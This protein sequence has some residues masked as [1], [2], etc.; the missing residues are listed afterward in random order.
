MNETRKLLFDMT[1]TL[2]REHV[3]GDVRLAAA[4]GQWPEGLWR[5]LEEAGL[6][7]M[8]VPEEAGGSGV[9]L[10]DALAVLRVAGRFAAP[11]PLAEALLASWLLARAGLPV[12]DGPLTLAPVRAAD[13]LRL[14]RDGDAWVLHGHAERVPWAR[15]ART[16]V[17]IAAA[18][19]AGEDAGAAEGPAW[20][21]TVDRAACRIEPGT[22]LADEPRDAIAFDGVRVL[23][24]SVRPLT[25]GM[26]REA[27]RALGALTRALLIAGALEHVLEQSVNHVSE[28]KQFGRPLA[29]FQV[30]QHYLARMA[31]EVAAVGTAVEAALNE[32][33]RA[34]E[35]PE[36]ATL[37]MAVAKVR[38]GEAAGMAAATAHQVHGAIGFTYDHALH[39]WTKR[40]W[41]WR[42]EFG[43]EAQWAGYLGE[44][45]VAAG[46]DALWPLLTG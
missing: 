26:D 23:G 12:P 34:G 40:L 5:A 9:G 22:N 35:R 13:P 17:V 11:A 8:A 21:A 44:R 38:A 14:S 30:L 27:L 16:I 41:S 31:G 7:R 25:D 29:K 15:H 39:H 32:L 28:R 6:P 43:N 1:T 33:D 18:P 24:E 36:A 45:V 37:A 46:G 20:A 3:T 4:Q 10:A 19:G 2:L 42:D